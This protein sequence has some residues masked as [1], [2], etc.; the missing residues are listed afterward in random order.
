LAWIRQFLNFLRFSQAKSEVISGWCDVI[1]GDVT[2]SLSLNN[3]SKARN[4]HAKFGAGR[5]VSEIFMIFFQAKFA[6]NATAVT[7]SMMSSNQVYFQINSK[8]ARNL[9]A[10]FGMNGTVPEFF[11]DFFQAAIT[12]Q[13]GRRDV[14]DDVIE[15]SLLSN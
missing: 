7:S 11:Y 1:V 4:L 14:I 3:F 15:P 8:V 10:K 5:T 2:S 6:S 9:H 12:I 13:N